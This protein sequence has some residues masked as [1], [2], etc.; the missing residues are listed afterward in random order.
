M[1]THKILLSLTL[2]L[3]YSTISRGDSVVISFEGGK[4]QTITLDGSIKAIT[5][6]QYLPS[7]SDTQPVPIQATPQLNTAPSKAKEEENSPQPK[8]APAK[9]MVKFKWAEPV[10]G[11]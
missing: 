1:I 8:Q 3:L 6:V 4:T 10:I 7:G 9:P 5:A 11:Q 2:V